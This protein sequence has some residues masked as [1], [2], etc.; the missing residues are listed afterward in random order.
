[1]LKLSKKIGNEL[2]SLIHCQFFKD[3]AN[4]AHPFKNLFGLPL[5]HTYIL[6]THSV[7]F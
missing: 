2:S 5:S 4:V 6:S 7:K 3:K 1:M